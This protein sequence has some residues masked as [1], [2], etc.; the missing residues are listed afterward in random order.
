MGSTSGPRGRRHRP[1]PNPRAGAGRSHSRYRRRCQRPPGRT[2]AGARAD[3]APPVLRPARL[4]AARR[5]RAD[6]RPAPPVSAAHPWLTEMLEHIAA[7]LAALASCA[8]GRGAAGDHLASWLR[9]PWRGGY[10]PRPL[11]RLRR[12]CQ[13][14]CACDGP[15]CRPLSPL[16]APGQGDQAVR[17]PDVRPGERAG[18]A[19]TGA[20]RAVTQELRQSAGR[21][22]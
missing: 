20:C 1:C 12:R 14:R 15:G 17:R 6:P 3:R 16:T 21:C 10:L 18:P 8:P 13:P 9:A 22:W 19:E 5:R 4:P 2:P 7:A 11:R